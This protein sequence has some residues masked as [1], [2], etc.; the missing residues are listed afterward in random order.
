MEE[1]IEELSAEILLL[2]S[3]LEKNKNVQGNDFFSLFIVSTLCKR[4][5]LHYFQHELPNLCH[6]VL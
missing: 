5:I 6:H 3:F 1:K 2:P 4:I